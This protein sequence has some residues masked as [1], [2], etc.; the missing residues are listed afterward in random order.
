MVW[1]A[2]AGGIDFSVRLT[3]KGGADRMEGLEHGADGRAYLK[4]RVRAVPEKGAANKAL[5]RLVAGWLGVPASAVSVVAGGTSRLKTVRVAGE[6]ALLGAAVDRQAGN[7]E[8]R[9]PGR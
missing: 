2:S 4:A 3:P 8:S 5:E 7:P 1:R 6:P 9:K